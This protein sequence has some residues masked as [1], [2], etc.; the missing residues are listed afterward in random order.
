MILMF[1]PFLPKDRECLEC[2]ILKV[3]DEDFFFFVKIPKR[4]D[5]IVKNQQFRDIIKFIESISVRVKITGL[6]IN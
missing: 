5:V 2:L 4:S 6:L 1:L 3:G